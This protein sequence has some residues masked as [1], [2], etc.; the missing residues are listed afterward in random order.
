MSVD[1]LCQCNLRAFWWRV[2]VSAISV[3]AVIWVV[4]LW[5]D[6]WRGVAHRVLSGD[7]LL[8]GL[9][10]FAAT[11]AALSAFLAYCV[12]VRGTIQKLPISIGRLFHFYFVSQILKHL[13][14]RVWGIGY[15]MVRGHREG[16]AAQWL[17][18]NVVHMALAIYWAM[19]VCIA[20]LL[21]PNFLLAGGITLLAAM[22]FAPFRLVIPAVTRLIGRLKRFSSLD[23]PQVAFSFGRSMWAAVGLAFLAMNAAQHL[24]FVLYLKAMGVG[25][26]TAAVHISAMYMLAWFAGYLAL[27]TPSGLGVRELAF[28]YLTTQYEPELAAA[29]A[30]LGRISFLGVDVLLG[31]P[32]LMIPSG[33]KVGPNEVG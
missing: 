33:N 11:C 12:I 21:F 8:F 14:G 20:L 22:L 6:A 9:G 24:G 16:G 27:L 17:K 1:S 29:A 25:D 31:V 19:V 15:Q 13:P 18:A 30:V 7:G 32:A 4:L 2:A 26:I 3:G 5:W 10:F 28:A 23:Q